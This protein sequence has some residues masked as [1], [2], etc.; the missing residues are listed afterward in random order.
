MGSVGGVFQIPVVGQLEFRAMF[1]SRNF[2]VAS[3]LAC[4]S[5]S[6]LAGCTDFEI[7][8]LPN[9]PVFDNSLEQTI[10]TRMRW[11]ACLVAIGLI[12]PYSLCAQA[13]RP[14]TLPTTA[15]ASTRPAID[16]LRSEHD[17]A[18]REMK[19]LLDGCPTLPP[20]KLEDAVIFGIE[21]GHLTLNTRLPPT[22][23]QSQIVITGLSGICTLTSRQ[24]GNIPAQNA[25]YPP[26][27][28]LLERYR[29]DEPNL[30]D[31]MTT[32]EALPTSVHVSWIGEAKEG[33]TQIFLLDQVAP[34]GPPAA[35]N[36]ANIVLR[37]TLPQNTAGHDGQIEIK[38]R[39]FVTLRRE[40]PTEVEQYLGPI[41]R[42]LH[43][44]AVLLPSD[45]VLAWQVFAPDAKP[46]AEV[47]EKIHKLIGRLDSEE[48]E[49][50]DAAA[51]ELEKLGPAALCELERVDQSKLSPEQDSR[52]SAILAK[53]HPVGQETASR[54]RNDREFLLNCLQD[55]D[56]FVARTALAHLQKTSP[57]ISF[58]FSLKDQA[59]RD[60]IQRLREQLSQATH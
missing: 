20:A 31:S 50:R 16:P 25:A 44:D 18:R 11:S 24:I 55:T 54:L 29:F 22:A 5:A 49:D 36:P 1:L 15:T 45:T 59:R 27:L 4:R 37:V 47:L 9:F 30:T 58:D 52:V 53:F 48:Y 3:P 13:T 32:I 39:D 60:T 35:L 43:A 7:D 12:T 56:D 57:S 21:Q 19:T 33:T 41:F 34:I 14:A 40:H 23:V 17:A 51:R 42:E 38:A 8:P 2:R 26:D 28:F 6:K 10:I 46:N